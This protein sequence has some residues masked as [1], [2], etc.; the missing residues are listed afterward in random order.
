M[1]DILLSVS[2]R[3]PKDYFELT[4]FPLQGESL[5]FD[6]E[7]SLR[8]ERTQCEAGPKGRVNPSFIKRVGIKEE[9]F[10]LSP[11]GRGPG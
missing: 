8:A 10:P 4:P 5:S 2:Q 6:P 1:Q 9:N 7:V 11:L 3:E